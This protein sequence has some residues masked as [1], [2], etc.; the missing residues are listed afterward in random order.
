MSYHDLLPAQKLT[1]PEG[2]IFTREQSEIVFDALADERLLQ[3]ITYR[4]QCFVLINLLHDNKNEE[5]EE[6]TIITYDQIGQLFSE[7]R[8][9]GSIIKAAQKYRQIM[10]PPHR[11]YIL[12]DQEVEEI[13]RQLLSSDDYP[14][15]ED[16]AHFIFMRFT[17]Y[18]SKLTIKRM[19]KQRITGYKIVET[20]PLD[21][22]RFDCELDEIK[23]Y[24]KKLDQEAKNVP[25]GFIF[26]LDESG[27]NQYQDSRNIFVVVPEDVDIK[28]YPISRATKR[29]TLLHCISTDGSSCDPMIIVPRLTVDN[30]LF[31]ELTSQTVLL[32]SQTKGFCTHELF[33]DWFIIKFL[34][35]LAQQRKK[36]N[37][38]GKAII[39]MDGFKGHEKSLDTIAKLIEKANV[40]F[41]L[42]P[43][44]SSDQVQPL[45]LFGFNL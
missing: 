33:T 41:I 32:R 8:T 22:L 35:Y 3:C 44:H 23:K 37:Y 10:K 5:D 14:T 1:Y 29:I 19:I 31:D 20:T 2:M 6:C 38:R 16:I 11:P 18:P 9:H 21:E 45:D 12:N 26:N 40:K 24:Y 30:E 34:P 13:H 4:E 28:S 39:I 27:Q 36:Y 15:I 42:I 7:P 43:P 25:V 17:K